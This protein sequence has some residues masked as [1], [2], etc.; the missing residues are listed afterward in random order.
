MN[1]TERIIGWATPR[2][3]TPRAEALKPLLWF[4]ATMFF[5]ASVASFSNQIVVV[6][7]SLLL[8]SLGAISF[9]AAYWWL[10]LKSPD[11][12]QSE[13]FM[14]YVLGDDRRGRTALLAQSQP[15]ANTATPEVVSMHNLEQVVVEERK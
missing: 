4:V 8:G 9:L 5:S 13:D 2:I 15:V 10:L 6:Y 3:P 1:S 11:R 14:A 7:A 12:L